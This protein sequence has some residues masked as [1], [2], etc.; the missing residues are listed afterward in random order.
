M[1]L[2]L[3]RWLR[4]AP[5]RPDV[6]SLPR[7]FASARPLNR[8]VRQIIQ[9]DSLKVLIPAEVMSNAIEQRLLLSVSTH[10]L[11]AQ[12][13]STSNTMLHR[14]DKTRPRYLRMDCRFRQVE[15][16]PQI[17]EARQE[18]GRHVKNASPTMAVT[19]GAERV[20]FAEL[21]PETTA[22]QR[23]RQVKGFVLLGWKGSLPR[24]G[25]LSGKLTA[26][27]SN[28]TAIGF[29]STSKDIE[30][31]RKPIGTAIPLTDDSSSLACGSQKLYERRT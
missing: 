2:A 3:A 16:L 29:D 18:R 7:G 13:A 14:M 1:T 24:F 20:T 8:G 28:V 22:V 9:Y 30:G 11:L 21:L 15:Q 31:A 17:R 23:Q 6:R 27:I 4:V 5:E 10:R 25:W 26:D 19:F 12:Q